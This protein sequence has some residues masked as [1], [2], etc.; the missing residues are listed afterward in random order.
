MVCYFHK[1]LRIRKG[2]RSK[3]LSSSQ[4]ASSRAKEEPAGR[5][6]SSGTTMAIAIGA[7][8]DAENDK[9]R[10]ETRSLKWQG[11]TSLH[12]R[13]VF[14]KHND[15]R[16]GIQEQWGDKH[17]TAQFQPCNFFVAKTVI[18]ICFNMSF[19]VRSRRCSRPTRHL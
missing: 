13:F 15:D 4:L 11:H 14:F 17:E 19:K 2:R 7:M 3:A 1:M 5:T 6:F 16:R 8:E 12:L 9:A 10:K 18:C